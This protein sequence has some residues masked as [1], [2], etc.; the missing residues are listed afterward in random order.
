MLNS[1]VSINFYMN[2]LIESIS[3]WINVC[4]S[5]TYAYF[6]NMMNLDIIVSAL[7]MLM[8]SVFNIAA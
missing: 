2:K 5:T 6:F 7:Q 4:V 3:N 1:I 8:I